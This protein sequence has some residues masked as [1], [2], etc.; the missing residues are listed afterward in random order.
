ME[1]KHA[2]SLTIRA[3]TPADCGPIHD[4]EASSSTVPWSPDAIARELSNPN[5]FNFLAVTDDEPAA[6]GFIFAAV[7][8]DELSIHNIATH[9]GMRRQGIAR[10]LL[11]FV[12]DRARSRGAL[13]AYL[14]VRSKNVPAITLYEKLGFQSVSVRK[15]YYSVDNDDAIIMCKKL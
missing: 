9:S 4:I 15:K 13:S 7:V 12:L 2:L 6:A 1:Q 11:E 8:A 5:G 14:E 10:G 3:A